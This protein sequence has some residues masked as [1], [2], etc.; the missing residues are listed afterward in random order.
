MQKLEQIFSFVGGSW[1]CATREDLASHLP[2]NHGF[3]LQLMPP[4]G[5][6]LQPEERSQDSDPLQTLAEAD[7]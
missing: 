7:L 1:C 5:L 3:H 2:N 4:P 6:T